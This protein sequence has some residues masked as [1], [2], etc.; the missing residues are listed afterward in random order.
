MTIIEY[1]E[2][3][4]NLFGGH[5]AFLL[6]SIAGIQLFRTHKSAATALFMFGSLAAWCSLAAQRLIVPPLPTYIIEG[7]DILGA[8][9]TL[10]Q[11]WKIASVAF[12]VGVL[13]AAV[14]R[15]NQQPTA[16]VRQSRFDGFEFTYIP[17]LTASISV[18]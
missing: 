15:L 8:V 6:F 18:S 12:Y 3:A 9:G 14:D 2:Y 5:F 10:P 16:A 7:E 11:S 1:T 13:A 17:E 4:L